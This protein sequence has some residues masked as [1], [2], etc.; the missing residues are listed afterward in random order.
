MLTKRE[1]FSAQK[2]DE[3]DS[4]KD[5]NKIMNEMYNDV[6]ASATQYNHFGLP[7]NG[8]A[9]PEFENPLNFMKRQ[10]NVE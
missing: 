10:I 5:V 3:L 1:Q 7:L 6:F 8:I 2:N 4:L 9:N